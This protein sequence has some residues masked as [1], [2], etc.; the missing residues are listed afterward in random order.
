MSDLKQ[1]IEKALSALRTAHPRAKARVLDPDFL[2][3]GWCACAA[4]LARALGETVYVEADGG[5]VPGS[6]KW[7]ADTDKLQ[8]EVRPDGTHEVQA[9]RGTARTVSGYGGSP[10]WLDPL[11]ISPNDAPAVA[12]K[13]RP[14]L[15]KRAVRVERKRDVRVNA[16]GADI[17]RAAAMLT[18]RP[19]AE[20]AVEMLE[21]ANRRREM[22]RALG[23][24]LS[25]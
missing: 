12:S 21:N 11:I 13:L 16:S 17:R 4:E 14:L 22:D 10:G 24:G 7:S 3:L 1:D 9:W 15:P 19:Y 2:N 18:A 25:W 23:V 20:A 5:A 6:Y 8:I